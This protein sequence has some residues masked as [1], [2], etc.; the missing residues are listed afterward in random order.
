MKYIRYDNAIPKLYWLISD[1]TIGQ[2]K[3]LESQQRN[4]DKLKNHKTMR[5]IMKKF[6]RAIRGG[7]EVQAGFYR[8]ENRLK[9]YD[10]EVLEQFFSKRPVASLASSQHLNANDLRRARFALVI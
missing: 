7:G 8:A 10:R 3:V 6:Q 5:A 1:K 9:E 2:Y 4:E